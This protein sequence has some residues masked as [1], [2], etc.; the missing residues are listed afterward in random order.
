MTTTLFV[1]NYPAETTEE[2]LREL[3]AE[4]GEVAAIT[5]DK[6]AVTGKPYALVTMPSEKIMNR[7]NQ[8]LNGHVIADYRLAVSYP[9]PQ[10]DKPLTSKQQKTVAQVAEQLGETEK[11]PI[12]Q[13]AAMVQLCGHA[14]VRAIVEETEAL[15][16]GEG[17]MLEREERRRTKGGVFFY[18]ARHRM[19]QAIH[20]IIYNRG[21]KL[22]Q[23]PADLPHT[24]E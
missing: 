24:G 23:P 3:F 17:I 2:Q 15:E 13:I 11:K 6:N 9:E 8:G 16:A 22:P 19:A 20:Q 10:L 5:F 7:A 21:G 12:R 1:T 14:F 18:L 4:Y